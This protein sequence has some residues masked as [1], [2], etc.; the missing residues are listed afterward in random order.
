M[1]WRCGDR[2]WLTREQLK[3]RDRR[4]DTHKGRERERERENN[5]KDS[6]QNSSLLTKV[7]MQGRVL[8]WERRST[9]KGREH[10]HHLPWL[11]SPLGSIVNTPESKADKGESLTGLFSLFT[12]FS[13]QKKSHLPPTHTWF[14]NYSQRRG[15]RKK[16]QIMCEWMREMRGVRDKWPNNDNKGRVRRNASN[17]EK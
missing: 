15:W 10:R 11:L 3:E 6:K 2:M 4:T 12:P 14:L 9:A 5:I 17:S 8:P 13:K 7:N 1:V 16:Y